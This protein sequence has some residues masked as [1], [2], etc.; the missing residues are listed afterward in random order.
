MGIEAEKIFKSFHFEGEEQKNDFKLV[1][2]KYEDYIIPKRNII[3]EL[4]VFHQRKQHDNESVEEFIR[5]LYELSEHCK[6]MDRDVQIK[7]N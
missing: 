2:Q 5:L 7:T 4:S 6:F 1:L 3:F